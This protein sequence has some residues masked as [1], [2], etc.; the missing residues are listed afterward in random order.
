MFRG[1][2]ATPLFVLDGFELHRASE[3]DKFVVF[4]E[5]GERCL[6]AALT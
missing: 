4:L 2:V 3:K 6:R 5:C 1:I